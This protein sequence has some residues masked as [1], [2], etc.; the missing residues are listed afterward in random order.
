MPRITIGIPVFNEEKY[1]EDTLRSAISQTK[2]FADI[3]ILISD[4][5]STD[6][7]VLK[8]E[9]VL[10]DLKDAD[11]YV[12]LVK[13]GENLGSTFNFWYAFDDSDSE[14]FL[15]LGAHDQLAGSYVKLGMDCLMGSRETSMFCGA[16]VAVDPAG[17]AQ[18]HSIIYDFT[19]NNPAERYLRSI[20][21]LSNCY[22]FQSIFRRDSMQG[23]ARPDVP[24]MDHIAISRWLWFGKLYQSNDC[25]YVRRYFSGEVR[26][27]KVDSGGGGY[28]GPENNVSFYEGYLADLEQL[29]ESLP[30]RVTEGLIRQAYDIMVARFGLPYA[31]N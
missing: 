19:Q 18:N 17:K 22:I 24:S 4:N 11:R 20:R 5:C 26:S 27:S 6:R 29:A 15:C 8:I 23:F 25:A 1:I 16:H 2:D 31:A 9:R 14:Y 7:T 13:H 12:R 10:A 3:E 30:R 21:D 28:V